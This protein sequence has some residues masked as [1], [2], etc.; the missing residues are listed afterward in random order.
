MNGL[1]ALVALVALVLTVVTL[2]IIGGA[3]FAMVFF[4]LFVLALV[5]VLTG[6][7]DHTVH[8]KD[9]PTDPTGWRTGGSRSAD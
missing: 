5:G 3:L 9:T 2:P 4:G 8:Q 6:V 7:D 1:S